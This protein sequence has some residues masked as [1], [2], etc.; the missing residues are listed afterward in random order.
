MH[1]F[2]VV[3]NVNAMIVTLVYRSSVDEIS[4][5]DT[6]DANV[7]VFYDKY[8]LKYFRE[9]VYVKVSEM[10]DRFAQKILS[11]SRTKIFSCFWQKK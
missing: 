4:K 7:K 2:R 11:T 5:Y 3:S 8:S 9:S 1:I 10:E 6:Y